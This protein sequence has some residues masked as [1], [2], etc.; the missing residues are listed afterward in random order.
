MSDEVSANYGHIEAQRNVMLNAREQAC[1]QINRMFGT[2]ISVSF[3]SNMKTLVNGNL[4]EKKHLVEQ[5]D[6]E[7]NE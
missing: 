6:G 1:E 5:A 7:P 4:V 2:D 3:R